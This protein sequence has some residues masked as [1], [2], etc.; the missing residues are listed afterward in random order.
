M[1]RMI[2]V[3]WP[4][5]IVGGIAEA[6]FFTLFDPMDLHLFGEPLNLSR[7]A[8]YTIGFF[9]FWLFAAGS[10]AFTCFLQRPASDINRLCPLEP[11]VRPAGCPKRDTPDA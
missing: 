5:F 4:S 2:W 7:T 10:S 11:R 9:A 3:L 1:Q 8:I 6:V